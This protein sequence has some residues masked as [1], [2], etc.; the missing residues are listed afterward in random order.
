[1]K[2]D[3]D[4][5]NFSSTMGIKEMRQQRGIP[6]GQREDMIKKKQVKD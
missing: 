1:V 4:L 3:P 6:R 2:K 5:L